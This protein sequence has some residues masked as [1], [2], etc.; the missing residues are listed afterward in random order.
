MQQN[1]PN[2]VSFGPIMPV[3]PTALILG[4]APS[5]ASL[6][7]KEY[8]G[9]KHNAFWP[10]ICQIF[11]TFSTANATSVAASS[12]YQQR[13]QLLIR[14]RIAL[15]DMLASCER[16]GSL[17]SSINRASEK[18]NPIAALLDDQPSIRLVCCNG[19]KAM[20]LFKR[21]AQS[22]IKRSPSSYNLLQ[23]PSTSPAYASLNQ[24]GKYRK[25]RDA[26]APLLNTPSV[27]PASING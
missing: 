4:S 21:H 2:I 17:D 16:A 18:P 10:I 15:W 27:D 14:C 5:D 11:S 7:N 24:Q 26:L 25:W 3:R 19:G 12:C 9:N 6:R 1:T 22:V 8:Y 13:I 20:A 23:L